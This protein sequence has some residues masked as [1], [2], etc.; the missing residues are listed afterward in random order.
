MRIAICL[1]AC[2]LSAQ[3]QAACPTLDAEELDGRQA[4]LFAKLKAAKTEVEGQILAS[5]LWEIFSTAPD[6]KAQELLDKGVQ[7]IG[8]GEF[9]EAET[10]LTYL[11][12]Y[13]P[14]YA[15]GWNQRA[16]ARYLKGEYDEA[17]A[18]LDRTLDLAQIPPLPF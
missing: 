17:L 2:L 14:E 1:A 3:V 13:C 6:K 15:E 12:D 8:R 11:I 4:P 5:A 7:S 10:A 16:F 9:L 18:D